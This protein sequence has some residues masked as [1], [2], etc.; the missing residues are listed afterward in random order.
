MRFKKNIYKNDLVLFPD[1]IK[2]G[3]DHL[4]ILIGIQYCFYIV[5]NNNQRWYLT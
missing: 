4:E 2:D 1:P 3:H 5:D